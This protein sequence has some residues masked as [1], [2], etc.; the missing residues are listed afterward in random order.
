MPT[1]LDQKSINR[2]SDKVGAMSCIMRSQKYIIKTPY[3]NWPNF[4]MS[5]IN[6]MQQRQPLYN[7]KNAAPNVDPRAS[8][9]SPHP[10]RRSNVQSPLRATSPLDLA[11]TRDTPHQGLKAFGAGVEAKRTYHAID[12]NAPQPTSYTVADCPFCVRENADNIKRLGF[13]ASTKPATIDACQRHQAA[14]ADYLASWNG[15]WYPQG[16]SVQN[17]VLDGGWTADW[18][19]NPTMGWG[20]GGTATAT[21]TPSRPIP[22]PQGPPTYVCS[23]CQTHNRLRPDGDRNSLIQYCMGCGRNTFIRWVT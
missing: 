23:Y 13:G 15:G 12:P 8:A 1:T 17:L 4:K 7:D 22:I 19:I 10:L 14:I 18:G 5:P 3:D 16:S 21:A 20:S 2:R 11:T 9:V 6:N